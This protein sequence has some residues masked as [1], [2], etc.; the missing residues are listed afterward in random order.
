[1]EGF[2][3]QSKDITIDINEFKEQV[4]YFETNIPYPHLKRIMLETLDGSHAL[5]LKL[6]IEK[7]PTLVLKTLPSYLKYAF[8]EK[9]SKLPVV[10]SSFLSNVQKEKL[11]RVLREHNKSLGWTIADIKG[12]SPSICTNKILM[13]EECKPK[14]QPQRRLN[15]NMKKVVRAEVIK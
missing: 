3:T 1:M 7:P 15:P 8:L 2:I 14:V 13:E 5:K 11:L 12:I 6:S 4:M 9:D 10:I